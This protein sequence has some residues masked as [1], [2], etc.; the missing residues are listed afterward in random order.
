MEKCTEM[1]LYSKS[2][3]ESKWRLY[4]KVVEKKNKIISHRIL[5]HVASKFPS[6]T[7]QFMFFVRNI[8]VPNSKSN[9]RDPQMHQCF[10]HHPVC[11]DDAFCEPVSECSLSFKPN[12]S[13]DDYFMTL[14]MKTVDQWRHN[15]SFSV[16]RWNF[17]TELTTRSTIFREVILLRRS[18]RTWVSACGTLYRS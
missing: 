14:G 7:L 4:N 13:R 8:R 15:R 3:F 11:Q 1:S 12:Q 2:I 18:L 16:E 9:F 17:L 10:S 6:I 5:E